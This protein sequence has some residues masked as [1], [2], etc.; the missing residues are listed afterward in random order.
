MRD[1]PFANQTSIV[2]YTVPFVMPCKRRCQITLGLCL[3]GQGKNKAYGNYPGPGDG[4]SQAWDSE[5]PFVCA[6]A[7]YSDHVVPALSTVEQGEFH[8]MVT[9]SPRPALQ[10]VMPECDSDESLS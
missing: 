10:V 6:A 7:F 9:P 4:Y 8:H 1:E 3:S 2:V 5:S